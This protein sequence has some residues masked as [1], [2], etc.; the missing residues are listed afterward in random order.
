MFIP[1]C[2]FS[3]K[4]YYADELEKLTGKPRSTWA[5]LSVLSLEMHLK[6]ETKRW[7]LQMEREH[8]FHE[9]DAVMDQQLFA[10]KAG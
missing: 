2:F 7:M 4:S 8:A 5:H 3:D 9:K 1:I 10:A 6:R